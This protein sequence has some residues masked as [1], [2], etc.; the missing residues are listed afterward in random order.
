MTRQASVPSELVAIPED[1]IENLQESK[2]QQDETIEH[3]GSKYLS[4][5]DPDNHPTP[6]VEK[7]TEATPHNVF[8]TTN[9]ELDDGAAAHVNLQ[10]L[11]RRNTQPEVSGQKATT[12]QLMIT[13]GPEKKSGAEANNRSMS[14]V[15]QEMLIKQGG[16]KTSAKPSITQTISQ[17]GI[18]QSFQL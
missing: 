6:V 15:E 10:N 12:T 7:D 8:I 14:T 2:S 13:D 1:Q 3:E 16:A 5:S 9:E 18:V 4:I 17:D 11:N